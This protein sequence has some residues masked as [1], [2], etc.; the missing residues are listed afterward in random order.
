MSPP[1]PDVL[2]R[3]KRAA[4]RGWRRDVSKHPRGILERRR[5]RRRLGARATGAAAAGAVAGAEE[6]RRRGV[7]ARLAV[8]RR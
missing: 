6:S 4:A 7:D 2:D 5:P 1:S 3:R 8:G